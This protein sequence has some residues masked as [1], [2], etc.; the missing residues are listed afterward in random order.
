MK[1]FLFS[2]IDKYIHQIFNLI[3]SNMNHG[4]VVLEI[5]DWRHSAKVFSYF[6]SLVG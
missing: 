5:D 6:S 3:G 2:D 4:D 1:R